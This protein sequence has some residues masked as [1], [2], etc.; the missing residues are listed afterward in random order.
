[1]LLS[2]LSLVRCFHRAADRFIGDAIG[3]RD[4]AEGFALLKTAEDIRPVFGGNTT[5][6]CIRPGT[7]LFL[8]REDGDRCCIGT[9]YG[10]IV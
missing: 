3:F 4:L 5:T 8:W 10:S 1:M 6:R 7:T 9:A 2:P